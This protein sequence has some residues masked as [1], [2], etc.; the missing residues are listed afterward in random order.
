MKTKNAL[1]TASYLFIGLVLSVNLYA[2]QVDWRISGGGK[3]KEIRYFNQPTAAP[4]AQAATEPTTTAAPPAL[5]YL[6]DS[7]PVDGF[8]PWITLLTT[9]KREEELVLDAVVH[10]SVTGTLTNSA[11]QTQYAIGIFDTGASAHVLG[12]QNAQMLKLFNSTYK[13]NNVTVV[14]GVTGEVDAWVSQP[15]G[16]FAQGLWVLEPNTPGDPSPVL[17]STAH[18]VG[19]SNVSVLMGSN[20]GSMPDLITA[21]G[22]P[23]SVYYTTSIKPGNA[24]TITRNG[25]TYTAP[26]VRIYSQDDPGIPSYP[27]KLPLELRPLGAAYVQYISYDLE[28]IMGMLL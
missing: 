17:R 5:S 24:V 9:N 19:Q 10:S 3:I 20:P 2:D 15:L 26:E 18:F 7:P 11:Y 21:I 27:N 14:S 25:T 6:I 16:L 28:G 23:L 13:T 12:Y 1:K 4:A 22:T 8:V